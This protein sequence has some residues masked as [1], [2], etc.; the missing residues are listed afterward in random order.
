[1]VKSYLDKN[2]SIVMEITKP[3]TQYLNMELLKMAR[4]AEALQLW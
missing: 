4:V 3:R 2:F 1:M